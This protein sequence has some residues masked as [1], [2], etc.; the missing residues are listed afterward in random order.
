MEKTQIEP[1]VDGLQRKEHSMAL[2]FQDIE[3]IE[4]VS[5]EE[6]IED[7]EDV[8]D[9]E[10]VEEDMP[11]P[12]VEE[13]LRRWFL[14]NQL[15]HNLQ[16]NQSTNEEIDNLANSMWNLFYRMRTVAP[17]WEFVDDAFWRHCKLMVEG[18]LQRGNGVPELEMDKY[19]KDY[20]NHLMV[21]QNV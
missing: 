21:L 14:T 13:C 8:E 5:D 1:L 2:F 20:W 4:V 10:D 3:E 12:S 18:A 15:H 16:A 6:E 7:I 19:R 17:N 11:G 9:V